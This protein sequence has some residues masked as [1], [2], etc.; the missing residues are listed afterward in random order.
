MLD[1][2]KQAR[3]R[4]CHSVGIHLLCLYKG[5]LFGLARKVVEELGQRLEQARDWM[6]VNKLKSKS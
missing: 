4:E 3:S 1:F 5:Q 2:S 6:R